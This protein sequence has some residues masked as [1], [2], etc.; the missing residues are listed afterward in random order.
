MRVRF[1]AADPRADTDHLR[2]LA[3]A[4]DK[5]MQALPATIAIYRADCASAWR[6]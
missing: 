4:R 1:M 5:E 3:R 6:G 2:D